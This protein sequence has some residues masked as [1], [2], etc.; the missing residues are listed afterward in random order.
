MAFALY[1]PDGSR[2]SNFLANYMESRIK[3]DLARVTGVGEVNTFGD[4]DYSM[5]IWLDAERLANFGLT[6]ADVINAIS[7]QNIQPAIG[8]VGPRPRRKTSS[9]SWR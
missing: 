1:S 8:S 3:D 4:M 7:S 2:D 5:R 6:N 9:C